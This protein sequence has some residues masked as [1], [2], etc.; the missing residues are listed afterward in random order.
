MVKYQIISTQNGLV[1]EGG[2]VHHGVCAQREQSGWVAHSLRVDLGTQSWGNTDPQAWGWSRSWGQTAPGQ[3]HRTGKEGRWAAAWRVVSKVSAHCPRAPEPQDRT[4]PHYS[5]FP[6]NTGSGDLGT[7]QAQD[8][9]DQ[10]RAGRAWGQ[11]GLDSRLLT[12]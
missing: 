4:S 3:E 1:Q 7:G 12:P 10:L 5:L 6:W 8:I 9:Q 11:A 2:G